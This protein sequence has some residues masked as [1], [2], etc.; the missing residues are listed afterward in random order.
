MLHRLAVNRNIY[1]GRIHNAASDGC[2]TEIYTLVGYIMLHR[3]ADNRNIYIKQSHN[4]TINHSISLNTSLIKT[5]YTSAQLYQLYIYIYIYI[6]NVNTKIIVKVSSANCR[7]TVDS[8]E[9]KSSK[10][11]FS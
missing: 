3:L 1:I 9:S 8:L 6:V 2:K 11:Y 10:E 4:Q 7:K 5:N